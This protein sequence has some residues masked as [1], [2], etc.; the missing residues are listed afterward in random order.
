MIELYQFKTNDISVVCAVDWDAL[1]PLNF[2][3]FDNE[4]ASQL[5]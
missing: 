5:T 3:D 4:T 2:L 1:S